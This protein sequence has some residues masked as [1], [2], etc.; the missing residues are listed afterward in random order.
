MPQDQQKVES[1]LK[2][3]GKSN[4]EGVPL[5]SDR[6]KPE[7]KNLINH[8][9][10]GCLSDPPGMSMY[11]VL[12]Q[13]DRHGLTVYCCIRG[14][15]RLESYHQKLEM[16]FDSWCASPELAACGLTLIRHWTNIAASERNRPGFPRTG[17]F[18]HYL[19]DRVQEIGLR[20]TGRKQFPWWPTCAIKQRGTLEFG[21]V[22]MLPSS[23]QDVVTTDLV[24]GYP[25]KYAYLA[26]QTRSLIPILAVHTREE[27]KLL[28]KVVPRYLGGS[29]GGRISSASKFDAKGTA[30]FVEEH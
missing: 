10:K 5:L 26:Y 12:K 21:F 27:K 29:G 20:L 1:V 19:L 17:H 25:D 2:A 23:Q 24:K 3:Q 28:S 18:D 9:E 15:N 8:A 13:E 11:Y 30:T 22:P 7:F 6:A 4:S 16:L 14:T